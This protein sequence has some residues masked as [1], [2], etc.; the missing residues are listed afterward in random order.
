LENII[1]EY[2]LLQTGNLELLAK[3]VVE[4]FI[5]GLH[6]SPFHG[7]SVEFAEHRQY[8]KGESIKHIDWKLFG[9]TEKLYTK[10]YEEETNLRCYLVIDDS[11][12][13]YFPHEGVSKIQFTA[14]ASACITYMLKKQR[15]SVGLNI[16]DKEVSFQSEAKSSSVHTKMIFNELNKLLETNGLNKITNLAKGLHHI[17][18]TIHKRALVI[19]FT[20]MFS[21]DNLEKIFEAIQ[22]L[23]YNKHEVIIF[24][25]ADKK[26]ESNFEFSKR[27]YLFI[28]SETN[29]KLKIHTNLVAADYK[30]LFANF[31]EE[32]KL[33]CAQLKVD[34]VEAYIENN[35]D[36]ILLK[37]LQKREKMK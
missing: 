36:Q 22:H 1:T 14:Y 20:D 2:N 24:H 11:S 15:D 10:R 17:A 35:I 12:S 16:I 23:K 25:V 21:N 3:Q 18:E 6:K 34:F 8:N 32:I 31:K 7:F 4:G 13:M 33:K 19:I 5:T 29:E 37:F 30:K 28:D 27:P 26:Y 9:K